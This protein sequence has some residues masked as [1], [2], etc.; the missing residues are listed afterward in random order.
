[1]KCPGIRKAVPR[2]R[3]ECVPPRKKTLRVIPGFAP[4]GLLARLA[5]GGGAG[6]AGP[7]RKASA[8][9]RHVPNRP[10][11]LLPHR[12]VKMECLGIRGALP[13]GRTECVPPRKGP[14]AKSWGPLLKPVSH[15]LGRVA[16]GRAPNAREGGITPNPNVA[17]LRPP[18]CRKTTGGNAMPCHSSG[19]TVRARRARPSEKNALRLSSGLPPQG[20]LTSER[21]P[22]G[23]A[24]SARPDRK[25]PA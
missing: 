20:R 16:E 7:D 22:R 4:Q 1:M 13:R 9:P 3:T 6:S 11:G 2:G 14:F 21:P 23:G 17:S 5:P 12:R 15:R 18:A 10:T 25:A 19:R 24:G 8:W